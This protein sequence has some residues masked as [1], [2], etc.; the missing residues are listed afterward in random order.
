MQDSIA[1]LIVDSEF[2]HLEHPGDA[3]MSR[4]NQNSTPSF[5]WIHPQTK[6]CALVAIASIEPCG[7]SPVT[8]KQ[9]HGVTDGQWPKKGLREASQR[10]DPDAQRKQP[11]RCPTCRKRPD[12]KPIQHSNSAHRKH[13]I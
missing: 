1:R 5:S 2:S 12:A 7:T 4:V 13:Y 9:L 10:T 8:S 11:T 6:L 3:M